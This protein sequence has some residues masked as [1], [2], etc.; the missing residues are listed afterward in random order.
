MISVENLTMRFGENQL[1]SDLNFE[2]QS[3]TG[4][5]IAGP[6]GIG[7]STL[8]AAL[9]GDSNQYIGKISL[10]QKNVS[11]YSIV[12]LSKIRSIMAQRVKPTL[13]LKVKEFLKLLPFLDLEDPLLETLDLDRK[14]NTSILNLSGGE[15]QRLFF[16]TC[17]R[18]PAMIYLFDE[19]TSNQDQNG[20]LTMEKELENLIISGK[21]IIVA[22][23]INFE[24]FKTF[25][26]A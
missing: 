14:L 12:E 2:V 8:L 18:Q 13:P 1:F 6:N 22:S 4:L 24:T 15:L 16:I 17:I 9:S 11:E 26:L 3:G 20:Q 19:P 25:D 21:T 7:K 23:H 5:R 10:N